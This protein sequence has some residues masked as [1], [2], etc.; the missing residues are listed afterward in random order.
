MTNNIKGILWAF[1][2]TGLFAVVAAMA[3]VAVVEY[4]V[5]QILFFRQ[6][7]V[8]LSALPSI[9]KSFPGSLKS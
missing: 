6:V 8:F 5:L 2:A 7:F 9:R 1:I 3:K 4:H